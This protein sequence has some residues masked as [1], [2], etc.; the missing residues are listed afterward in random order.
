MLEIC[1]LSYIYNQK[2]VLH[3]EVDCHDCE[4]MFNNK[5]ELMEHKREMHYKKGYAHIIM[6]M[7]GAVDFPQ[8]V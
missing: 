7:A 1:I 4:A 2:K 6:E 8:A 3:K 5:F